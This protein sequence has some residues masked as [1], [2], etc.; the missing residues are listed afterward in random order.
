MNPINR[1]IK[2]IDL[3]LYEYQS[4]HEKDIDNYY[5]DDRDAKKQTLN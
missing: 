3:P 2:N 5:Y 1:I 4:M